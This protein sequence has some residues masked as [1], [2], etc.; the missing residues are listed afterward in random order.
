MEAQVFL[1]H[2]SDDQAKAEDVCKRLETRGIKCWLAPRDV[3]P[4]ADY[5]EQII[6]AIEST[7]ATVLILSDGANE[8]RF[9]KNEVE[10]AIAKGKPVIPFRISNVQ[11]SRALE[12]FISRSQWIDAWAPPLEARVEVLATAIHGLLGLPPLDSGEPSGTPRPAPARTLDAPSSS[13][14]RRTWA[15]AAAIGAAV[16]LAAG[17]GWV[18]VSGALSSRQ[19]ATSKT[20]SLAASTWNGAPAAMVESGDRVTIKASGTWCLGPDANTGVPI[21]GSP[22]GISP[23]SAAEPRLV[24]ASYFGTLVAKVGDGN[25]FAVGSFFEWTVTA[26]GQL[27]LAFNERTDDPIWWTDNTGS[28]TVEVTI[29]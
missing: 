17:L 4:G 14:G 18:A 26:P 5:G 10:R 2:S 3:A 25:W 8:S 29:N 6:G 11:P 7:R 24:E 1:S 15:I 16:V 27:R 20:I 13:A 21:C 9:V 19:A 22:D 23:P 12:L 28:I